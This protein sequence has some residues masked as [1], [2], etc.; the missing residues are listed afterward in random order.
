[1]G[2]ETLETASAI[3]DELGGNLAV[4]ELFKDGRAKTVWHWRKTNSFPSN[5]YLA[6]RD[7]LL[8]KGKT[9]PDSLWGMK[10]T[11]SETETAA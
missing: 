9:A 6:I 1:M 2:M 11:T 4:A 8:A 7:A 3:I 5:T 10:A